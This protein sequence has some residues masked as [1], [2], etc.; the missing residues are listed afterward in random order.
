MNWNSMHDFFAMGGYGLYV[1]G[2]VVVT[3]LMLLGEVA[4]LKLRRAAWLK[5]YNRRLRVIK[6]GTPGKEATRKERR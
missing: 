5:A 6:A 3:L 2:S 1:W 4:A